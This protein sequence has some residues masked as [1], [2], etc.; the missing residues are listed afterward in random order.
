MDHD[1]PMPL[2]LTG[3][4]IC[5]AFIGRFLNVCIAQFP[6]HDLLR[7]QLKAVL[8]PWSACARCGAKGTWT[9]LIPIVG[10]LLERRRCAA[11]RAL[12]SIRWPVIEGVTG[13]LF[14]VVY[15]CEIGCAIGREIPVGATASIFSGGL[16]SSEGPRGPEVI[17]TL[18]SPVVWLHLRYA[19]HMLMICG[20]VVATEIDR[21]LRIIPDGC[22]VPI[23]LL[24]VPLSFVFG[25][26]YI[27]PVWFQDTSVVRTLR[28]MGLPEFIQPLLVPWDPTA[29]IQASPHWHGLLV[30]VLGLLAGA[31]S[32]WIVRQI[33]F[34][35][36][37]Q[38]AMGFGDVVLMAMVGSVIG[39]QPVLAVF[40]V[41]A[42]LLALVFA[43]SNWILRGEN[44]IPYGPFLSGAT[45]LLLLTWPYSWPFAKRFFDMGPLLFV[46]G[47]VAV[48][49]LA[50]SLSVVHLVK[51]L[52]GLPTGEDEW[53]DH[54]NGGWSSADHLTYYNA[55]RPDEQTGQWKR[56]QW[57]GAR[58]GRGLK[59]SHDWRH[60][61]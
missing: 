4:V 17:S 7:D 49:S 52:L 24:A 14:A 13:V 61:R 60:G 23:M 50:A 19:F 41:G 15:W 43:L 20:L 47:F 39:W 51:K 21:R 36:L 35:T 42:P 45:I 44:E 5:G 3:L 2:V 26:L 8:P 46:L 1:I 34:L 11:C 33:G 37:K 18:W 55:E 22:T 38:E 56:D 16:T 32:V 9:G 25:Q 10:W 30:S 54:G 29:F 27:V 40:V 31:G 6:Q 28:D 12:I 57:P 48:V 58:A 59:T 53:D